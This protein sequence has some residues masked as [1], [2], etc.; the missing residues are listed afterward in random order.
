MDFA[1]FFKPQQPAA[2]K[3]NAQ[4]ANGG[5]QP[6]NQ[7]QQ[8][9]QQSPN[10]QPNQQTQGPGTM[11]NGGKDGSNTQ[12]QAQP[13]PMDKFAKMFDN[14]GSQ[15]DAAPTFNL[16]PKTL[17]EVADSQ[18]FMQG[19]DPELM[20][21]AT[22]G[23]MQSLM[24][25]MNN[26][27]RNAYK[28]SLSHGGTLSSKYVEAREQH[29]AKGLGSK[30]KGE[31]TTAALSNIPSFKHPVVQR[32]LKE[33]A[34]RLSK[35]HPDAQPQEIAN[36]AIE[37]VSELASAI[38]PATTAESGNAA[39]KSGERGEEYWNEFFSGANQGD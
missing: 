30:V 31:L 35:L 28:A 34:E 6:N 2:Q 26:V 17:G 27:G 16:D 13:Q 14:E 1:S 7:G 10:G 18:D 23:D 21:K 19:I 32:Q 9:A 5:Q 15:G 36:M 29:T 25:L 11:P 33:T 20:Q 3:P 8:T 37:Y 4:A 12:Q 38:N 22:S 39:K 24:Q